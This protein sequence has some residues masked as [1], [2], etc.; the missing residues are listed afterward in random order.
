MGTTHPTNRI[1]TALATLVL[2]SLALVGL[3]YAHD[4]WLAPERFAIM[5]GDTLVVR[6]LAGTELDTE[7]DLGLLR[8]LTKRFELITPDGAIDLLAGL[9][10]IRT[11]PEIKPVL[12][13]RLDYDGLG[14]VVMDHAFI[15][16]EFSRDQ[17]FENLEHEGF[18]RGAF[19]PYMGDRDS[20]SERYARTLKS[21][22]QVGAVA[23][24]DLHR[25]VVGQKLEILLLQNPFLLDPG[26]ELPVQVLFEGEP[27]ARGLV[28]AHNRAGNGPVTTYEARTN[29]EGIAT[30]ELDRAG[31][32]LVRLIHMLPCAER[33]DVDCEDVHWESYWSSYTFEV[34]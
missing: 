16:E 15:W 33:A 3:A 10:D 11:Q 34:R 27:L 17:F 31:S 1:A 18:A 28:K 29:D 20:Q 21:L 8:T 26:A 9:P 25:R 24:G 5:R 19:E 6:Q 2:L 4:V 22:V 30:F 7:H 32:W 23:D 12:K 14:L 13:R